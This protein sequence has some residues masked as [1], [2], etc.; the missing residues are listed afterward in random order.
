MRSHETDISNPV[1]VIKLHDQP[2]FVSGDI[3]DNTVTADDTRMPVLRFDIDR[4]LPVSTLGF[5]KPCTQRLFRVAVAGPYP[6][7]T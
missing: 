1:R 4:T 3:E 5:S 2:V 6:K 7:R